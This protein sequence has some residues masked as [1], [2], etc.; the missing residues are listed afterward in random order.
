VIQALTLTS[1]INYSPFGADSLNYTNVNLLY[2][3]FDVNNDGMPQEYNNLTKPAS[4]PSVDGGILWED[5][6][7]KVR[8]HNVL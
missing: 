2:A 3:D 6:I 7:N 8:R 1:L 4:V 5:K